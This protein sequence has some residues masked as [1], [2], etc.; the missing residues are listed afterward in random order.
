M[1]QGSL[2]PKIKF[3]G[4]KKVCLLACAHTDILTHTKVNTGDTL[5]EFHEVFLQ[6][7]IKGQSNKHIV[8]RPTYL[9][10]SD[11]IVIINIPSALLN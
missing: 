9:E 11:F 8:H 6:P 2:T 7:I 1:S 5:S 4:K 3:L 10:M